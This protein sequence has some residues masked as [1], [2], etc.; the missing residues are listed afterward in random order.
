MEKMQKGKRGVS[1]LLALA[2]LISVLPGQW[3]SALAVGV[4][5]DAVRL[6]VDYADGSGDKVAPGKA[7]KL[8]IEA[9]VP[10][11][12]AGGETAFAYQVSGEN[13]D[14]V[15]VDAYGNVTLKSG[16]EPEDGDTVTVSV[17]VAAYPE[18]E[19][20][21]Y[22]DFEGDP[23]EIFPQYRYYNSNDT[24]R[25]TYD[26][27]FGADGH[28]GH[29]GKDPF[30]V[31][32]Q[33]AA[34]TLLPA[35]RTGRAGATPN[36]AYAGTSKANSTLVPY[37]DLDEGTE[38][39]FVFW[40]YDTGEALAAS[41]ATLCA[42]IPAAGTAN[43]IG[44]TAAGAQTA[45]ADPGSPGVYR[46]RNAESDWSSLNVARSEGWHKFEFRV[47]E[48]G[49]ALLID[50]G[51]AHDRDFLDTDKTSIERIALGTNFAHLANQGAINGKHFLDSLYVLAPDAEPETR[52]LEVEVALGDG[53]DTEPDTFDR[54]RERFFEYNIGR[55]ITP[56][57]IESVDAVVDAFID[58]WIPSDTEGRTHLF[59]DY[60]NAATD[61]PESPSGSG[62]PGHLKTNETALT[63]DRL[64][65]MAIAAKTPGSKYNT[66]EW[67]NELVEGLALMAQIYR[68]YDGFNGSTSNVPYGSGYDWCMSTPQRYVDIL[69]LLWEDLDPA[70]REDYC[71]TISYYNWRLD[72][73]TGANR[74]WRAATIMIVGVLQKDAAK[75]R[76][77]QEA[78]I[79][80]GAHVFLPATSGDG[81][82][83]DGSF[84]QH[85]Y[86]AYTGGYGKGL[87]CIMAQ[88]MYLFKDSEFEIAY[89]NHEEQNFYDM[90]FEA[91]EPVIYD[92]R[93]M[94]AVR[95]REITRPCNPDSL[96]G[97][98]VLRAIA[99]LTEVLE[100]EQQQRAK[101]MLK[102]ALQDEEVRKAVYY[103]PVDGYYEDLMPFFNEY[104]A[105]G[106]VYDICEEIMDDETIEP[107]GPLVVNKVYA[108]MDRVVHRT[109]DWAFTV[110]MHS[111]RIRTYE[112]TN[113]E[114]RNR[115]YIANG[116]TYLYNDD[117]HQYNDHYY[118]A[119][120]MQRLAG[121]TA[122]HNTALEDAVQ[123]NRNSGGTNPC[124]Y[125]GGANIFDKYG[126]AGMDL[127]S[128]SPSTNNRNGGAT[129]RKSWFMFEDEV[130][131]VGS[132]ISANTTDPVETIIDNKKIDSLTDNTLT[133]D[134]DVVSPGTS[135]HPD[136]SWLH[137]VGNTETGN[138][139]V[140]YY[141]P[142][143]E[144]VET[145]VEARTGQWS[146]LN[147]YTKFLDETER[148]NNYA[149]FYIN[150]GVKPQD[151]QYAYAILPGMS[152]AETSAYAADPNVIIT[153]QTND[154]HSVV[155]TELGVAAANLWT[156]NQKAFGVSTD[157][158]AAVMMADSEDRD[159]S[160]VVSVSDPTQKASVMTV[161]LDR[162]A[163]A[164]V[165]KDAGITV[166]RLEP[167]VVFTVDTQG[168]A[169]RT[170]SMELEKADGVDFAY[171]SAGGV[172]VSGGAAEVVV[173]GNDRYLSI[174]AGAEAAVGNVDG[175]ATLTLRLKAVPGTVAAI[176]SDVTVTFGA[177]G[178]VTASS[179]SGSAVIGSYEQGDDAMIR[180]ALGTDGYTVMYNNEAF[181]EK[182]SYA[183]EG[184]LGAVSVCAGESA[185]LLRGAYVS[186]YE[187]LQKDPEPIQPAEPGNPAEDLAP[188]AVGKEDDNRWSDGHTGANAV[189]GT[190][191]TRWAIRSSEGSGTLTLTF[192]APVTVSK[193]GILSY[194]DRLTGFRIEYL[195]GDEWKAA[196]T[197]SGTLT[198][199]LENPTAK[200]THYFDFPAVTAE[201][202]RLVIPQTSGDPSIWKF[203]LYGPPTAPQ[204]L[205][206][207]LPDGQEAEPY[208]A[209]LSAGGTSP[210]TWSVA[211]GSQLPEGLAL[212]ENG[213]I[214]GTPARQ[215]DYAF[216]VQASNKAGSS[217]KELRLH[218]AEP[219][220]VTRKL[221]V[222]GQRGKL[223]AGAAGSTVLPVAVRNISDGSYEVTLEGAPEGMA[224]E[225][226]T[227]T[228]GTG[229]LTIRISGTVEQGSYPVTVVLE[230]TQA[231]ITVAV[232][233]AG[234]Y[235]GYQTI[236]AESY[237]AMH[238]DGGAAAPNRESVTYSGL[239]GNFRA[240]NYL[241]YHDI[242]FGEEEERV[243]GSFMVNLS[244]DD[245]V[246][247]A[248]VA[249][250]DDPADGQVLAVLDVET[251][252]NVEGW[253]AVYSN[254][255]AT[256]NTRS[257]AG[258]HDVYLCFA[259]DVSVNLDY[260]IFSEYYK[261][262]VEFNIRSDGYADENQPD[263]SLTRPEGVKYYF[264]DKDP[265]RY[266][267]L[268]DSHFAMFIHIGAF[269]E[270]AGY[271]KGTSP[272]NPKGSLNSSK[273]AEWIMRRSSP[274]FSRDEYR[275][276]VAANFRPEKWDAADIVKLAQQAG[277]KY[278]IVTTRHHEGF[279][280]WDTNVRWYRDYK[281]PTFS[282][283]PHY[284]YDDGDPRNSSE[285]FN[286][287]L[288]PDNPFDRDI[289]RE[290]SDACQ[291]TYGTDK[292]VKFGVYITIQD[293]NDPS[294]TL[295]GS[296]TNLS[297]LPSKEYN[298]SDLL[299]RLKA[300][301]RE[302]LEDYDAQA[303]WFDGS[304]GAVSSWFDDGHG[305]EL[306]EFARS[307]KPTVLVNRRYHRGG[308][309]SGTNPPRGLNHPWSQ[310]DFHTPEQSLGPLDPRLEDFET[311]MTIGEKFGYRPDDTNYKSAKTIVEYLVDCT[312]KGG[313]LL[314]NIC[315]DGDGNVPEGQR[316]VLEEVGAW[317][318]VNSESI[319]NTRK[320]PMELYNPVSG[321]YA[322]VNHQE[323]KLFVHLIDYSG[324]A[325]LLPLINKEITG[326]YELAN[327]SPVTVMATNKNTYLDLSGIE[328]NEID[329]VVVIEYAA[330]DTA[331]AVVEAP[332]GTEQS[333]VSI[334]VPQGSTLINFPL[335][336]SGE[337]A[338]SELGGLELT[339]AGSDA[340]GDP[341]S[342]TFALT[343]ADLE[344]PAD[345]GS[346]MKPVS[347]SLTNVT[348]GSPP[349][350]WSSMSFRA[351]APAAGEDIVT[352]AYD[353][354]RDANATAPNTYVALASS[355]SNPSV[356][357][358]L[359]VV[360]RVNSGT[361]DER[362][363]DAYNGG[364]Y[365]VPANRVVC[366]AGKVYRVEI[367]VN[368]TA[369]T[370][371]VW[372]TPE[373]GERTLIAENYQYR[374]GSQPLEDIGRIYMHNNDSSMA[375]GTYHVENIQV[376]YPSMGTWSRTVTQADF[377]ELAAGKVNVVAMLYNAD[378]ELDTVTSLST[379]YR[380][381]GVNLAQGKQADASSSRTGYGPEKA[382]NGI[383][384]DANRWAPAETLDSTSWL[385]V[386]LGD[387]PV[388]FNKIIL[389]EWFDSLATDPNYRSS[390]FAI[391]CRDSAEGEW[392]TI[393]E[394]ERIEAEKVILLPETYAGTDVRLD[395]GAGGNNGDGSYP[396]NIKQMEIYCVE[397][398]EPAVYQVTFDLNGGVR[399]GGGEL[400]Q[401]VA[402][403]AAAVAPIVTRSG[404]AFAGWDQDFIHV[405]GDLTVRA[406]WTAIGGSGSGG[407]SS[408]ETVV[409]TNPDGSVVTT[410]TRPDGTVTET[411]KYPDGGRTELVAKPNGDRTYGSQTADGVRVN[412]D[413]PADGDAEAEATVPAGAAGAVVSFPVNGGNVVH[414]FLD[415]GSTEPVAW[416]VVRDGVAYVRLSGSAKLTVKD[417]SGLFD[418][419]Q[420]HW[421]A[422]AA[423]FTGARGL[424]EGT[425]PA[426]FD[427]AKP[428][429]RA[430]LVTVLY[431]LSGAPET[432]AA[433]FA[434]VPADAWYAD[435]VAWA[436]ENGIAR[437]VGG[438][439]FQPDRSITRQ[440][441]AVMLWNYARQQGLAPDTA[442][443]GTLN[444]YRD[445]A[446]AAPWAL[447]ALIWA[448]EEGILQGG[449]DGALRPGA[450]AARCEVAAMLQR[451]ITAAL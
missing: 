65:S 211:A 224:A 107:R 48:E 326:A 8:V 449:T 273:E 169:G 446:D 179:G 388:A 438:G 89:P 87:I 240:G 295:S 213:R 403:G 411:V 251:T 6:A 283:D 149:T 346:A 168:S 399:T 267:W 58:N 277:Q 223:T 318:D 261:D 243:Y 74:V 112:D 239:G 190:Y 200:D 188:T 417:V 348:G 90:I 249:R 429:T 414:K 133:V 317:M 285:A 408:N 225:T 353:F 206:E 377:P 351:A 405:H 344:A 156:A 25:S 319:Y 302:L 102:E 320:S 201:Q 305:A 299:A 242:N 232:S 309:S 38:G 393:F 357:S 204:I 308:T 289:I 132:G 2:I 263:L 441:L 171:G 445:G 265:D 4:T 94:D 13:A 131:C 182:L 262:P 54:L 332:E 292:E 173:Q 186:G 229:E 402:D 158:P 68:R 359:P 372:V 397:E 88:I 335:T 369:K 125:V 17:E 208:Q 109:E 84:I 256:I 381:S 334:D 10:V 83:A 29:I 67:I 31:T 363:F 113:L 122:E 264:G 196:F 324:S 175:A 340:D 440:E 230:G 237:D 20:V 180:F 255:Y 110:S 412:A 82:Y 443:A 103:D 218:V 212:S 436:A 422:E 431:R 333:T 390:T 434:D 195:D 215:G 1:L 361:G 272:E 118:A 371:S 360:V 130:L 140:G 311:C 207:T 280:M 24:S 413:I 163:K 55:E 69:T 76:S 161:T 366:E 410:V 9:G 391:S 304:G 274:V 189:D 313:N 260:F 297:T 178:N 268:K 147:G 406:Q 154:V 214:S 427:P 73:E 233:E 181:A 85:S 202:I 136:A 291:A 437:G 245:S 36:N 250:L 153:G 40:Y 164:V 30:T 146:D 424:F 172:Q 270:Q 129:S 316:A 389:S 192:A 246:E 98:Q 59:T 400:I 194:G 338:I 151:D 432:G 301:V 418:D 430:M 191:D 5:D 331:L 339:L 275:E 296:N 185:A 93:L 183:A 433:A 160:F 337:Y 75:I 323:G 234:P 248:I 321:V 64:R 383:L 96:A 18:D 86:Y 21:F 79:A 315:P 294:Q 92:G 99:Q 293:W 227:L 170:F 32:G 444:D 352:V 392:I 70:V 310:I 385:S 7:G 44:D 100:G 34:G 356:H 117:R 241:V 407:G 244:A 271:N 45:P 12:P 312:A 95:E 419:M 290:L 52:T 53:S 306:Y 14:K 80:S 442:G 349:K 108:S 78:L 288:D 159:D 314:L 104:G 184:A 370:F 143:G 373:G 127:V 394:G 398:T 298:Y 254:Q 115:W 236:N 327:G 23:Q 176:G 121:T 205:T 235:N 421:A 162:P 350:S 43:P 345:T 278:I 157:I 47:S 287:T 336:V 328:R 231:E 448:T 16:Y 39:T 415:D 3:L 19:V 238:I 57:R 177:E 376:E 375:A 145:I 11:E 221:A 135:S 355:T 97:S 358:D 150:H 365:A 197:Y 447:A 28:P 409:A 257:I 322:T 347:G 342:R 368:M 281:L 387:Q 378:R 284:W 435:G 247:G 423:D 72:G 49:M 46:Y 144:T 396:P 42:G 91:Y 382:F 354:R 451:L 123:S 300:S 426:V 269:S 341:V 126:V 364:N 37:Y 217:T 374:N 22:E 111:G 276:Y 259:K 203:E 66:E 282:G 198:G 428:M 330:D 404:Y 128:W 81:F 266:D 139:D 167:T 60:P 141:F 105:P 15:E 62:K 303:L 226:L 61:A 228:G 155:N 56:E 286:L 174:P 379:V 450:Q 137:L 209:D 253:P 380:A 27:W 152:A 386:H 362:Y 166:T 222:D 252:G 148:T 50:G 51:K 384:E 106:I 138:S 124:S 114:G 35:A 63:Y 187:E 343:E 395:L 416:S 193:T 33:N 279:A 119:L 216:E 142:N 420:Q 26:E 77:A 71:E 120:D 325:I 165:S 307:I 329:T 134:G 219:D 210:I 220:T 367:A 258:V 41:N 116:M 401:T 425:A 199:V 439:L 101:A